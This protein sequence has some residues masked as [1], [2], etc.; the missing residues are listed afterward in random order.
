MTETAYS[1]FLM[2]SVPWL[3]LSI[4]LPILSGVAVAVYGRDRQS[5]AE[6]LL[7]KKL[8]LGA[9]LV[10]LDFDLGD[11]SSLSATPGKAGAAPAKA[12]DEALD[13][14]DFGLDEPPQ[15]TASP[16][17]DADALAR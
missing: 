10:G 8:A 7:I 16:S 6:Q 15:A 13:F 17:I 11:I 4:W 12:S 1:H 5:P 3:S 14:G 2:A 9:S